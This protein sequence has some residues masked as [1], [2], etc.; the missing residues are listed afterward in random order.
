MSTSTRSSP[1]GSASTSSPTPKIGAQQL[2]QSRV[3]DPH[4]RHA[5]V[6][7]VT[8]A[9]APRPGPARRAVPSSRAAAYASG[10]S[11]AIT[12]ATVS[13]RSRCS[14]GGSEPPVRSRAAA[15]APARTAARRASPPW[16]AI[17]AAVSRQ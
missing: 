3:A 9:R 2:D 1:A 17:A 4:K 10:P 12:V 11:S 13:S 8:R 14:S 16:T 5:R 15:A 7:G 6:I